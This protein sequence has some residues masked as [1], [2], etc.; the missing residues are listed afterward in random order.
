MR[1]ILPL[2][3]VFIPLTGLSA[4]AHIFVEQHLVLEMSGDVIKGL[5]LDWTFDDMT[6]SLVAQDYPSDRSGRF[7][8]QDEKELRDSFFDGL[9]PRDFYIRLSWNKR[10]IG[11]PQPQEFRAFLRSGK[12]VYNFL[13]PL[14]RAAKAGDLLEVS[15]YDETF[16]T[17]MYY[18]K[19]KPLEVLPAGAPV[20]FQLK[21]GAVQLP[22]GGSTATASFQF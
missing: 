4:H 3:L 12:L 5:R 10:S 6:S 15:I 13:L 22:F 21:A 7:R 2:L 11:V 14:N 9:G 20:K 8:P 1:L 17:D 18:R 16:F 19:D